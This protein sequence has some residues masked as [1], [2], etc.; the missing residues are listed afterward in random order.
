MLPSSPIQSNNNTI[1]LYLHVFDNINAFSSSKELVNV[2]ISSYLNEQ[3]LEL[4]VS[5]AIESSIGN[6]DALLQVISITSTILNSVNCSLAV[7]NCENSFNRHKC[8][9]KSHT[10]GECIN[11]YIGVDG[12]ANSKCISLI[13]YNSVFNQTN[14]N[15]TNINQTNI[16]INNF[17][18]R[19]YQ[20]NANNPILISNNIVRKLQ[21]IPM[22]CPNN[23]C[24]GRGK[25]YYK[26]TLIFTFM[27]Y[28]F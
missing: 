7:N 20:K 19:N 22:T 6:I 3:E 28:L 23:N 10:C 16:T 25:K 9:K 4:K 11:G 1:M 13:E 5:S 18:V 8:N 15:R 27:K 2:L 14:I 26:I 21:Y 24:L 17:N 12:D